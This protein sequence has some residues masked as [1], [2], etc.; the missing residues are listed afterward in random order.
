MEVSTILIA[1]QVAWELFLVALGTA[2]V[3][4]VFTLA[5]NFINKS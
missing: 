1:G 3:A 4:Y 5:Q 2:F